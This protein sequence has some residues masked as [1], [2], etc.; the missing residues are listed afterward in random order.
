MGTNT[1]AHVNGGKHNEV[2][3]CIDSGFKDH[4]RNKQSFE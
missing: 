2:A 4:L 1:S 3:I